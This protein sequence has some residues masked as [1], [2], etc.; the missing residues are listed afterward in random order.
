VKADVKSICRKMGVRNRTEAVI[1][2]IK[3]GMG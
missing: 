2:A 1:K 3:M